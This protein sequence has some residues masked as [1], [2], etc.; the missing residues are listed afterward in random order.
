M[1]AHI[2][3]YNILLF[4]KYIKVHIIVYLYEIIPLLLV[5][6]PPCLTAGNITENR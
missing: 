1:L 3:H 5:F 4:N 2:V 6:M